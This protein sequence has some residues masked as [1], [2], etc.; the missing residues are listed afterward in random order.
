MNNN[1]NF[2]SN[3]YYSD[4]A[5]NK[6]R[7]V[8][9]AQ[10]FHENTKYNR[11]EQKLGSCYDVHIYHDEK[12]RLRIQASNGADTF[13]PRECI[14]TKDGE[15][16]LLKLPDSKISE[17][18]EKLLDIVIFRDKA[19]KERDAILDYYQDKFDIIIEDSV[20]NKMKAEVQDKIDSDIVAKTYTDSVFKD[21]EF[22]M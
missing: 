21:A 15:A 7:W 5:G 13:I 12:H 17:K 19:I 14:L 3:L 9:I 18:L 20:I 8:N 6:K 2:T 1:I 11:Y 4:I 16:N 10:T 22:N